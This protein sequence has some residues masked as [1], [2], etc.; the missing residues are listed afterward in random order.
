MN[1]IFKTPGKFFRKVSLTL[2]RH[3]K[4]Q[5]SAMSNG[6]RFASFLLFVCMTLGV[7]VARVGFWLLR[8]ED[9]LRYDWIVADYV[10]QLGEVIIVISGLAAA[11][12]LSYEVYFRT[13]IVN[14]GSATVIGATAVATKELTSGKVDARWLHNLWQ[15][16]KIDT[17]I[18]SLLAAAIGGALYVTIFPVYV[19]LGMYFASLLIIFFLAYASAWLESSYWVPKIKS[20]AVGIAGVLLLLYYPTYAVAK[21]TMPDVL[22]W[23]QSEKNELMS[24]S[25]TAK[26]TNDGENVAR[27]AARAKIAKLS[28]RRA[29]LVADFPDLPPDQMTE[30]ATINR[31][32]KQIKNEE[33]LNDSVP[34]EKRV[35]EKTTSSIETTT[36]TRVSTSELTYGLEVRKAYKYDGNPKVYIF[37]NDGK[38]HWI[39]SEA[40]YAKYYGRSYNPSVH[41]TT[42]APIYKMPAGIPASMF[43]S[44][45]GL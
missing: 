26:N 35:S 1:N 32:L 12:I 24:Q 44:D 13:V 25:K 40:A 8:P 3:G 4:H 39:T 23:V 38:L 28:T 9:S 22:D 5:I 43:G 45:I 20:W 7:I 19:S 31:K 6:L 30:L 33:F 2:Q 36:V 11:A 42:Y 10:M 41:I 18:R 15:A 16:K 17:I 37:G 27:E 21:K 34:E 29:E 14:Y